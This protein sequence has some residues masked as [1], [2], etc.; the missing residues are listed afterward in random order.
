MKK[1]SIIDYG[2]HWQQ[3][4][5]QPRQEHVMTDVQASPIDYS[6]CDQVRDDDSELAGSDSEATA[7]EEEGAKGDGVRL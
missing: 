6:Q 1:C 3:Q 7:A 2:V 5:Q 4:Q